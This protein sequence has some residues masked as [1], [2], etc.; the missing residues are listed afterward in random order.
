MQK[1]PE[2]VSHYIGISQITNLY[3][4]K[5]NIAYEGEMTGLSQMIIGITSPYMN[6]NDM[7]WFMSQMN[8]QKFF[9][10]NREILK[11]IINV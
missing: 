7:K 1:Y 11:P 8:T 5:L 3:E 9:A 2:N 10:Q 6:F 4:N